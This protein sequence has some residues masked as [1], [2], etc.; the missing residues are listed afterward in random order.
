MSQFTIL[1]V[2]AKKRHFNVQRPLGGG[3]F[4][5]C[6]ETMIPSSILM[7]LLKNKPDKLS[8]PMRSVYDDLKKIMDTEI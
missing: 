3:L 5:E 7:K 8:T 1:R 6:Q 2:A 4:N